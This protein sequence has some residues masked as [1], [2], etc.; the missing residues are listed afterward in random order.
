V[1][2]YKSQS[3]IN[4][5]AKTTYGSITDIF[6][7]SKNEYDLCGYDEQFCNN[8]PSTPIALIQ[9]IQSPNPGGESLPRDTIEV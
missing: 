7:L 1:Y 9:E 4:G 2:H 3:A 6:L 5:A 8:T